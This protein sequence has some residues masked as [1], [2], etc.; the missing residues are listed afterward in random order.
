MSVTVK[1]GIM[2]SYDINESIFL[3]YVLVKY[4]IIESCGFEEI[5]EALLKK[6]FYRKRK[7]FNN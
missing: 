4:R 2:F 6:A 5:P 3:G 7:T 1:C